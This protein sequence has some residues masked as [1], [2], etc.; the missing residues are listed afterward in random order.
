MEQLV[1]EEAEVAAWIQAE[2]AKASME[3]TGK[4]RPSNEDSGERPDFDGGAGTSSHRSKRRRGQR[5]S[6]R[7]HENSP[8]LEV[9]STIAEEASG[10][11]DEPPEKRSRGEKISSDGMTLL[12]FSASFFFYENFVLTHCFLSFGRR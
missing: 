2:R 7:Q 4:S 3:S 6:K 9:P 12:S 10:E 11:D 1:E 8:D 5:R